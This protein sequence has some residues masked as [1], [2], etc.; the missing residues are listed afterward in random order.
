MANVPTMK[1]NIISMRKDRVFTKCTYDDVGRIYNFECGTSYHSVTTALGNTANKQFLV[2]WRNRLGDKEADRQVKIAQDLGEAFHYCGEM[3][4][5]GEQR[6]KVY[7][8]VEFLW[9]KMQ[10]NLKPVTDVFSV[11]GVL[12]SDFIRLAGRG[13]AVIEWAGEL[14][15]FDFKCVNYWIPEFLHDYWL[16]CTIYAHMWEALHGKRPKKIILGIANKKLLKTKV[17]IKEP[18][19]FAKET[20]ERINQFHSM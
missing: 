3:Y 5:K 15:I 17:F 8:I 20:I 6:K 1:K 16:Q 13:D 12:Y 11:E 14:A 2:N 19:P 4:F 7:P 10:K 18:A 9:K